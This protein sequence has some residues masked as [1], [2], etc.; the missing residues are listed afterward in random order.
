MLREYDLP[1]YIHLYS[2]YRALSKRV[3]N[4]SRGI[5]CKSYYECRSLYLYYKVILMGWKRVRCIPYILYYR[6]SLL[7]KNR[8]N[9]NKNVLL[10]QRLIDN[11]RIL[12]SLGPCI[13]RHIVGTNNIDYKRIGLYLF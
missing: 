10:M 11:S 5:S 13:I 2:L 12:A 6:Y 3:Q 7:K 8:L 9:V 1:I 4:I